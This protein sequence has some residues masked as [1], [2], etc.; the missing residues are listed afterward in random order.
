MKHKGIKEISVGTEGL[1]RGS[2]FLF[3]YIACDKGI[4]EEAFKRMNPTALGI[5]AIIVME[6]LRNSILVVFDRMTPKQ[7]GEAFADS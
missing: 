1:L 2:C 7:M 6:T 5:V 4:L 3:S